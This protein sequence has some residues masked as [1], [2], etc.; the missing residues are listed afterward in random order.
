V[1][2]KDPT[3]SFSLQSTKDISK[4]DGQPLYSFEKD[5]VALVIGKDTVSGGDAEN[6]EGDTNLTLFIRNIKDVDKKMEVPLGE[7]GVSDIS[8]SPDASHIYIQ[9]SQSSVI[10]NTTT[11]QVEFRIPYPVGQFMWTK[12]DGDFVFVTMDSGIFKGSVEKN[13]AMNIVS[14]TAVR[15]TRISFI[16]GGSVY[17]TGYTT[18]TDGNEDPDAYQVDLEKPSTSDSRSRLQNFPHQGENFYIDYLGNM[19]TVQLTRYITDTGASE[20]DGARAAAIQ[21]IRSRISNPQ[22]YTVRYIFV[23]IDLRA[24]T[25][26]DSGDPDY[27]EEPE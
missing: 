20:A 5:T 8:L 26:G 4:Y 18:K 12:K 15:P 16:E 23:D 11:G 25:G 14:Y 6:P 7:G 17:F 13:I 1:G 10:F 3:T 9:N 27:F 24:T 21:Y 2:T 19:L 22:N